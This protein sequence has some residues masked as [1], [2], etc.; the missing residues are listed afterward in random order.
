MKVVF[1]VLLQSRHYYYD[2]A[3][4]TPFNKRLIVL[5]TVTGLLH[6]L[7]ISICIVTIENNLSLLCKSRYLLDYKNLE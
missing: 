3:I 5:F 6:S 1:S 7:V 4:V 2:H